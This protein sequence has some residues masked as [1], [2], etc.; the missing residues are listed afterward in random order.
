MRFLME[1][2]GLYL[3]FLP[4]TFKLGCLSMQ[5]FVGIVPAA[6]TAKGHSVLLIV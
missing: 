2:A 3:V 4:H 1:N 5:L 6:A